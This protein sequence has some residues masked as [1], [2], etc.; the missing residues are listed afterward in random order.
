[1][2]RLNPPQEILAAA[3]IAWVRRG[4]LRR[5][6]VE[7]I[8][9]IFAEDVGNVF[10]LDLPHFLLMFSTELTDHVR[11]L[12]MCR[13]YTGLEVG[14]P[15]VARERDDDEQ[16]RHSGEDDRDDNFHPEHP[17]RRFHGP[18]V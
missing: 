3:L 9:G 18:K 5:A 4:R 17:K 14:V 10:D 2:G 16:G 13:D 6:A 11:K 7:E 12:L 15:S 1:M 8:P